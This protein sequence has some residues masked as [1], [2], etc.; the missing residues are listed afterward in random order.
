MDG[1]IDNCGHDILYLRFIFKGGEVAESTKVLSLL[2]LVGL[3]QVQILVAARSG[4]NFFFFSFFFFFFFF[5]SK[6]HHLPDSTIGITNNV[7][8]L[9]PLGFGDR[10]SDCPTI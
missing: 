7:F 10:L 9:D 3:I 1:G 8:F 5:L 2:L 4:K 6:I